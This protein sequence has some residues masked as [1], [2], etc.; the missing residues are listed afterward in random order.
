MKFP[1]FSSVKTQRTHKKLALEEIAG[2]VKEPSEKI[3]DIVA[4]IRDETDKEEQKRLKLLLPVLKFSSASTLVDGSKKY[5][6]FICYDFDD[7]PDYKLK[8]AFHASTLHDSVALSFISPSGNG[9]KVVVYD[10][11][12]CESQAKFKSMYDEVGPSI[13]LAIGALEYDKTNDINRA[14]FLSY[15]PTAY[16]NSKPE[17]FTVGGR[18]SWA[19]KQLLDL[20]PADYNDW[21][22]GGAHYKGLL[23][24][25][26]MYGWIVWSKTEDY[27]LTNEE[28]FTKWKEIHSTV[29]QDDA[30]AEYKVDFEFLLGYLRDNGGLEFRWNADL[31]RPEVR[32]D[33]DWGIVE[34]SDEFTPFRNEGVLY[35]HVAQYLQNN[36]ATFS[37]EKSKPYRL[38]EPMFKNMYFAAPQ[39]QPMKE[40][41]NEL[42]AS[43]EAKSLIDYFT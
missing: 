43:V 35:A 15:D 40:Y 28:L 36:L 17:P 41:A 24:D 22:E 30:I 20:D 4:L 42:M 11:R 2:Q 23:G 31:N 8:N 26:G 21:Y 33:R 5:T 6:G 16:V 7:I 13:A 32:V 37:V 1:Y 29:E 38:S 14:C 19:F 3:K 10:P 9:L 27:Q 25:V 39:V 12:P 34:L 18:D